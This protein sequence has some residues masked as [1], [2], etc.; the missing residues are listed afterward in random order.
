MKKPNY[1]NK[2]PPSTRFCPIEKT[3]N[4]NLQP[5]IYF[6]IST[7]FYLGVSLPCAV[8]MFEIILCL[9]CYLMW[10]LIS[11][12]K[13]T[14]SS[15]LYTKNHCTGTKDQTFQNLHLMFITHPTG[16][17]DVVLYDIL[18]G[19]NCVKF[20][21]FYHVYKCAKLLSGFGI[22]FSEFL[23]FGAPLLFQKSWFLNFQVRNHD[24]WIFKLKTLWYI[25][26]KIVK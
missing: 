14:S 25:F 9:F 19:C 13:S 5:D 1:D 20:C 23:R 7:L 11:L 17:Q 16:D 4:I 21:T 8:W 24:F 15:D 26:W 12:P 10:I 22:F 2:F 6:S 18:N 3:Y